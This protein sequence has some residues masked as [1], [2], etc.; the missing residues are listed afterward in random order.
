MKGRI[1]ES[2]KRRNTK[3]LERKREQE[4]ERKQIEKGRRG[5]QGTGTFLQMLL[6]KTNHR[7][8]WPAL[9]R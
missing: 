1:K 2:G 4:K 9:L 6:P 5:G 8:T 3:R 7:R